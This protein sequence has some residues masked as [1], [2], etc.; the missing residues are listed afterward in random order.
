MNTMNVLTTKPKVIAINGPKGR[1]ELSGHPI[2]IVKQGRKVVYG[3][4]IQGNLHEVKAQAPMVVIADLSAKPILEGR[5]AYREGSKAATK[6]DLAK[7]PAVKQEGAPSEP[8]TTFTSKPSGK[9]PDAMEK[10]LAKLEK[11][12]EAIVSKLS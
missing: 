3:V 1:M 7:V 12:L 11:A 5:D 9:A 10:R 4:A 2:R 8:A 6:A